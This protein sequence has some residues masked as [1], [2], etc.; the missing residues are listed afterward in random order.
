MPLLRQS[1]YSQNVCIYLAPTAD[2]RDT[3]LSLMRTVA[4]EGRAFVLSA[5][6]CVRR[7]DLPGWITGDVAGAADVKEEGVDGVGVGVNGRKKSIT[8]EGPHEIVWPEAGHSSS[9]FQKENP[10][11]LE[12][13]GMYPSVR[14]HLQ[15]IIS[16]RIRLSR[17][18]LYHLSH[19]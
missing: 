4:F 3:W 2:A 19:G 18:L 5:N 15:L 10:H 13:K 16:Q 9:S 8:A 17:W 1:L 12:S 11:G 6:Q 14:Q 7:V